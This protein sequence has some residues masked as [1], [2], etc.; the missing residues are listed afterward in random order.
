MNLS[1]YYDARTAFFSD[2]ES[3][4]TLELTGPDL[5]T[6]CT[7]KLRNV[8]AFASYL[9]AVYA[10][11]P[12]FGA[13]NFFID[14][15][16]N[17]QD[18]TLSF[19]AFQKNAQ[20]NN[21]KTFMFQATTFADKAPLTFFDKALLG[22]RNTYKPFGASSNAIDSMSTMSLIEAE[23]FNNLKFKFTSYK[24]IISFS[25]PRVFDKGYIFYISDRLFRIVVIA[26]KYDTKKGQANYIGLIVSGA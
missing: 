24:G 11:E 19:K 22:E 25:S 13:N 26:G 18:E 12:L 3:I 6:G 4:G 21:V 9:S 5:D 20:L 23:E 10:M 1:Q 7:L 2:L 17:S 15:K 14:G 16:L 8:K